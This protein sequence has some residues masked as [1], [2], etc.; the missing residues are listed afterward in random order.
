MAAVNLNYTPGGEV[1]RRLTEFYRAR[2]RAG[3]GLIIVG[4]A[5]INDQAAGR[6]LS[7]A[8]EEGWTLAATV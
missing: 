2:A 3:T 5:E 6:H 4:S 1:P 7:D 8:T